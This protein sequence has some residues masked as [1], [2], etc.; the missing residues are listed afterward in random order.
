MQLVE[1]PFQRIFHLKMLD[2][3]GRNLRIF[4]NNMIPLKS[5]VEL[6]LGSEISFQINMIQ[7]AHLSDQQ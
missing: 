7:G 2:P 3:A 5:A 1:L 4:K 6:S